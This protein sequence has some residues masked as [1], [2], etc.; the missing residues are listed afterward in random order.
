MG[1]PRWYLSNRVITGGINYLG[2][3]GG[4]E[5]SVRGRKWTSIFQT[6]YWSNMQLSLCVISLLLTIGYIQRHKGLRTL[7][8]RKKFV[9][10]LFLFQ[11]GEGNAKS[12]LKEETIKIKH[13]QLNV[14]FCMFTLD[15]AR[16]LV[17][18]GRVLLPFVFSAFLFPSLHLS[19]ITPNQGQCCI[20]IQLNKNR[21]D[22]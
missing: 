5:K 10:F 12:S 18:G 8:D 6:L 19:I 1:K 17:L 3:G 7:N 21:A 4:H 11:T 20:Q 15:P 13:V 22:S 9:L 16:S 14:S 2:A